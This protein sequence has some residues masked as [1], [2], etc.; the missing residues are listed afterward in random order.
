MGKYRKVA[1][2]EEFYTLIRDVHEK[3]L[4]YAGYENGY[5]NCTMLH[6]RTME[7]REVWRSSSPAC[8]LLADFDKHRQPELL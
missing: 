4:H 6:I 1:F 5:E 3:E 8:V 2:V 7:F